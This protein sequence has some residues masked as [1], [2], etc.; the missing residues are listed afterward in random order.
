M[1]CVQSDPYQ[2]GGKNRRC[3]VRCAWRVR[4]TPTISGKLPD[5]SIG[6]RGT[7]DN[8][9]GK[10]SLSEGCWIAISDA[11]RRRRSLARDELARRFLASQERPGL[12]TFCQRAVLFF[13]TGAGGD[14]FPGSQGPPEPLLPFR[15]RSRLTTWPCATLPLRRNDCRSDRSSGAIWL[16]DRKCQNSETERSAD[17]RH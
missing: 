16:V 6:R 15:S 2:Q 13:V 7:H 5:G 3:T 1:L 4:A 11:D 9:A 10:W 8:L 12:N 17:H 14:L